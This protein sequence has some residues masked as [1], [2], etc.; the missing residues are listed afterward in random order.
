MKQTALAYWLLPAEPARTFFAQTIR[1]L[2]ARFDAPV[3]DPHL[4][5]FVVPDNAVVAA[6]GNS[7][8]NQRPSPQAILQGIGDIAIRLTALHIDYSAQFTKTLFVQFAKSEVLQQLADSSRT[9]TGTTERYLLDPHLSL[10]YKSLP[11]Q[12]KR[13]LASSI[14]LPFREVAFDSVC[15]V[16]C[17][18]PTQTAADVH[19]WQ[20]LK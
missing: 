20:L 9:L 5:F 15:A 6:A 8:R 2:A 10:L 4:T 19:D 3:F 13:E 1:E 12:S 18:S 14:H 7:G 16:S 17:P 11:E